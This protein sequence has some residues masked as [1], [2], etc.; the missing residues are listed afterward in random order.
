MLP[1]VVR[2]N[3]VTKACICIVSSFVSLE[4]LPGQD[5][6]ASHIHTTYCTLSLAQIADFLGIRATELHQAN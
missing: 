2:R 6:V 4:M 5:L 1:A 3:E